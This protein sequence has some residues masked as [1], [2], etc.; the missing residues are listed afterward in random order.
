[1]TLDKAIEELTA[2]GTL[3]EAH[4]RDKIDEAIKLGIEAMRAYAQ[5]RRLGLPLRCEQL[6]SETKEE[7][8]MT[9]R[10]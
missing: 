1:M 10:R 8:Q 7:S 3:V 2:Y 9:K 5:A 6:P 4:P